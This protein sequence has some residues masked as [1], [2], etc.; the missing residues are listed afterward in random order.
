MSVSVRVAAV[1]ILACGPHMAAGQVAIP[2]L[3]GPIESMTA[4]VSISAKADAANCLPSE[5]VLKTRF[6]LGLRRAGI[7][8]VDEGADAAI[9]VS[10]VSIYPGFCVV[11]FDMNVYVAIPIA[12]IVGGV[13]ALYGTNGVFN[14]PT[15]DGSRQEVRQGLDDW[16][17]LIVNERLKARASG[18]TQMPAQ[19][20][21]GQR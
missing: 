21:R 9:V 8:V 15:I 6:E 1:L 14:R 10:F 5:S 12:G 19:V 20:I 17:D 11:S 13:T 16:V 3:L 18:H 2:E 7:D 4:I